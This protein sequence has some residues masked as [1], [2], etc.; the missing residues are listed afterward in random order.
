MKAESRAH[1]TFSADKGFKKFDAF[2]VYPEELLIIGIDTKHKAGEHPLYDP[3]AFLP[4]PEADIEDAMV[5]GI[6]EAVIVA[7]ATPEGETEPRAVV[8]DGLQRT[9]RARLANARLRTMGKDPIKIPI[10]HRKASLED[11]F[12]VK[13]AANSHRQDDDAFAQAENISR[14]LAMGRDEDDAAVALGL[15]TQTIKMRL[16]LLQLAPAVKEAVLKGLLSP[17]AAAGLADLAPE[18]QVIKL[19][20]L[21]A[22]GAGASIAEVRRAV[23]AEKHPKG[24]TML[25][26]GGCAIAPPKK[27]A[28]KKLLKLSDE[29]E[30]AIEEGA[31]L[32]IRWMM[33]LISPKRIRGLVKALKVIDPKSVAGETEE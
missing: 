24:K 13:L 33:G 5:R 28:V 2:Y 21:L 9:K 18:D 22:S 27:R 11:L 10:I 29:K 14:F 12:G 1:Q 8:I 20:E 25:V 6:I 32:G 7:K 30:V 31:L 19:A 15:T 3:R 26:S 17:T 4:V 23:Q 16:K